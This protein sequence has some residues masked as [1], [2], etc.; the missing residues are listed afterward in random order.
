MK[1]KITADAINQEQK[2]KLLE[3]LSRPRS[4][5]EENIRVNVSVTFALLLS[6]N[7][8]HSNA[9]FGKTKELI[10]NFRKKGR[11]HILIYVNGTE[12][13]RVKS[14]KF[15]GVMITDELSWASH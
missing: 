4:I 11:E 3:K 15:L 1:T 2:W 6:Y 12:V 14:I 5:C 7:P 9:K 13:E 10:I 8:S